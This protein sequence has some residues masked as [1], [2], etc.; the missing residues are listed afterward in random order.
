MTR[1]TKY[2]R[3]KLAEARELLLRVYGGDLTPGE[4]KRLDTIINKIDQ[5]SESL[6]KE[7]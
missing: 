1:S 5:L 7:R 4:F 3:E 6:K 2:D